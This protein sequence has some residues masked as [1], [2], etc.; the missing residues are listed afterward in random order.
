MAYLSRHPSRRRSTLSAEF[1]YLLIVLAAGVATAWWAGHKLG[2]DL[3]ALS[4]AAAV[5]GINERTAT[6]RAVGYSQATAEQQAASTLPFCNAGQVPTFSP[7][8]AVL[9]RQVGDAMGTPIECE[10]PSTATGDTI[11]QTTTG[12]AAY[13]KLTNTVTFT[14]GWRHWAIT[15]TGYVRWEGTQGEPP[16]ASGRGSG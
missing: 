2:M 13:Y 7:G 11:Q 5:L 3:S 12:L 8:L 1:V 15:A 14:D 4:T 9:K 16:A 6:T 10:H